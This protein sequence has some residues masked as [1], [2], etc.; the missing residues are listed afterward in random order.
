MIKVSVMYPGGA[1]KKFDM[2]Y[3]LK[4]HGDLI[5]QKLGAALKR[6]QVD[7]GLAGGAPNS[8]PTYM[9]MGHL[10]FDSV[11]AFQKA[12]GPHADEILGDLPN[13]TNAQPVIQISDVKL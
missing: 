13:F 7:S 5:K 4:Q 6:L 1:G 10:Y 8:P 3:Y 2:D 12:F 11:D 9:A